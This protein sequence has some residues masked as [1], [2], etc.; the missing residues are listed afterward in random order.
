MGVTRIDSEPAA[1]TADLEA[2]RERLTGHCYRMLG[3]VLD[4]EDAV[5]ETML[6]ALR[7]LHRFDGRSSLGTWLFRIATNVC[8][9][10]LND[11]ARRSLPV[12]LRP[13]GTVHDELTT[14]ERTHWLEPVPDARVIPADADPSEQAVLRESVRLAFVAAIQHLPPKQR[15]ALLLT[16]VVGWSAAETADALDMT[17][18]AVNSALQRAR[19]TLAL[20]ADLEVPALQ[21]APCDSELLDR[22]VDAFERYDVDALAAMLRQDVVMSMPPFELWLRG[23]DAVR[24]WFLGRGAGCRGSRLVRL[25]ASGTLA[26]AQYRDGGANPWSLA[27]LETADGQ[28]ARMTY[29]LDTERLFPLWGLPE[30]LG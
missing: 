25:S 12:H 4:A 23:R 27:V 20:R 19:A 8:I 10:A 22:F 6:R 1:V 13:A 28:I 30:R 18:A 2:H 29:F 5:Q 9:D 3:S 11:R 21:L 15:A 24:E 7:S 14:Q 16:Q 17:V 26:F